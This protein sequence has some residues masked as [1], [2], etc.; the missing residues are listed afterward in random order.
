VRSL[1][2]LPGIPCNRAG[3]YAILGEGQQ[4]VDG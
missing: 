4:E 3:P 1:A 2:I